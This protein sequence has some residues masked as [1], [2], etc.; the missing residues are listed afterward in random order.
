M[1]DWVKKLKPLDVDVGMG[2]V[3]G[4][5]TSTELDGISVAED[6]ME[7]ESEGVVDSEGVEV[8]GE[9]DV[10]IEATM[11]LAGSV[12]TGGVA[13]GSVPDATQSVAEIV[14]V[15]T[16][17]TVTML[18]VPMTTVGVTIPFVEEEVAVAAVTALDASVGMELG[19]ID[20][21][22]RDVGAGVEADDGAKDKI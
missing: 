22:V 19:R 14:T 11:V 1:M 4:E 13:V 17:V 5:D 7:V 15:D 2:G 16:T 21:A 6:D 12:P 8:K 10:P 9:N 18:S 20:D 3:D